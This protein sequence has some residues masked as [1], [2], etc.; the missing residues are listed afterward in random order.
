MTKSLYGSEPC[1]TKSQVSGR[2]SPHSGF[3][4]RRDLVF[5]TVRHG[6]G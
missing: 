6:A 1:H 5:C 4:N 3:M 2:L